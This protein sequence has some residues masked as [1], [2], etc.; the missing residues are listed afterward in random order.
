MAATTMSNNVFL[1]FINPLLLSLTPH[2]KPYSMMGEALFSALIKHT[3]CQM[4]DLLFFNDLSADA[5]Y[6]TGIVD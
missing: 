1:S 6:R 3:V 4:V 2:W 5:D